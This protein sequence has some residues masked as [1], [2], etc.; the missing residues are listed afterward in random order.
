MTEIEIRCPICNERGKINISEDFMKNAMRGLIA[1]N[2]ASKLI[3]QDSFIVYID[4]N[5]MVRDYFTVDFQVELPQLSSDDELAEIKVPGKDIINIDL[6]KLNLPALL[7]CRV[8]RAIFF[9]KKIAIISHLE[10]LN[11]YILNFFEYITKDTFE[12][13]VS[14]IS[15]EDYRENKKKFKDF[16]V[17]EDNII[18]NN[19]D[20]IIDDKKIRVEKQIV[21]N[22]INEIDL[23]LSYVALKSQISKAFKLSKSIVN[24]AIEY[25]KKYEAVGK[26]SSES[27]FYNTVISGVV[28]KQK[29]IDDLMSNHIKE[30]FG[31]KIERN[32]LIFLFEIVKN[33]FDVNL[34]KKI[35]VIQQ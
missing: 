10:F 17:L 15:E 2:V 25:E 6:I 13:S 28:D 21:N 12:T 35:S 32:Y 22:F 29:Y 20:K 7:L 11:Q 5:L 24:F 3:C 16:M 23:G 34:T 1:V 19:V 14:I 8:L 4:K 31:I 30:R 33:Y 18:H 26:K 9:K 27:S